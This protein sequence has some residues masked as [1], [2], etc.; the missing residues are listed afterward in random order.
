[1]NVILVL[2]NQGTCPRDPCAS[3]PN[4]PQ[5]VNLLLYHD[6]GKG[7]HDRLH[8]TYNPLSLPMSTPT[9]A[10]QDLALR[11]FREA[12]LPVKIGG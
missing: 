3:L 5:Q 11:I 6:I 1:M 2:V 12:S 7:K 4:P 10:Q 8:T 9:Q